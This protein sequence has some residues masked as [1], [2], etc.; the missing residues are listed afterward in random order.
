MGFSIPPVRIQA[1]VTDMKLWYFVYYATYKI[2]ILLLI[3]CLL[4]PTYFLINKFSLLRKKRVLLQKE[5]NRIHNHPNSKTLDS[6]ILKVLLYST[7]LWMADVLLAI[8]LFIEINGYL[9]I[10]L[11]LAIPLLLNYFPSRDKFFKYYI[12]SQIGKKIS[13]SGYFFVICFH[14]LP[15]VLF[16]FIFF[17]S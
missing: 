3:Y 15:W 8:N 1:V 16:L 4:I 7:V 14:F 9:F 2:G 17:V 11:L 6:N 5:L 12:K 10:F 13:I